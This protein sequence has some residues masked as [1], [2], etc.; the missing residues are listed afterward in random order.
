MLQSPFGAPEQQQPQHRSKSKSR[1]S[2]DK[3][4][5]H[6]FQPVYTDIV[7]EKLLQWALSQPAVQGRAAF[8][9]GQH[10]TAEAGNSSAGGNSEESLEKVLGQGWGCVKLHQ[11]DPA[12]VEVAGD[13]GML[14]VLVLCRSCRL[15]CIWH[16]FSLCLSSDVVQLALWLAQLV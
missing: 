11:W 14:S 7:V 15:H 10:S 2:A 5:S 12:Q 1:H 13:E 8:G 16:S 6:P 9:D 4:K 3:H